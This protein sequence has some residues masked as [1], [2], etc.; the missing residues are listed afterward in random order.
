MRQPEKAPW[1]QDNRGREELDGNYFDSTGYEQS[2]RFMKT[3]QKIA[4]YI[5][6]EYKGGGVTR[7]EVMTPTPVNIPMPT[8]RSSI[9]TTATDGTVTRTPPD[10]LDISDY[11]SGK[12]L[13]IIRSSTRRR[14]DRRFSH[15]CGSKALNRGSLTIHTQAGKAITKLRGT[16]PSYGKVWYCPNGIANIISLANVAK[17]RLVTFKRYRR[18]PI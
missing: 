7:T 4:D 6:Q 1:E 5:G 11:Q 12:K 15:S 18:E 9:S 2:N 3:V 10:V 17:T 8:R 14:I 16:V 13:M